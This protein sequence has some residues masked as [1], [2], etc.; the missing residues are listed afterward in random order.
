MR[1]AK[2]DERLSD[3]LSDYLCFMKIL[4]VEDEPE[5]RETI[6]RSLAREQFVIETSGDFQS[7]SERLA[8]YSYDCVVL[9][10]MLPDGSGLE[11]LTLLKEQ[12][13]S[14]N[15]VIISA[16]DSLEDK[17]LGL[18]SGADDYLTKPFHIA[19]LHARIKA[20][21]RRKYAEGKNTLEIANVILD[22]NERFVSVNETKVSLNRKEFDI[23]S[24]F[25]FNNN[26]LVTKEALAEHVWGDN[27]DQSDSFDFIYYQIKNLRKKLNMADAGIELEAVYGIGYKLI[28]K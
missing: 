4:I 2:S 23:L 7:A 8:L 10:V 9:D 28:G 21:I 1:T 27:I 15:V 20:V 22:L 5:L 3:A 14:E 24:Y 11:L 6:A 25:M 19:E 17:L 12:G 26:R 13:K 18:E 16:R